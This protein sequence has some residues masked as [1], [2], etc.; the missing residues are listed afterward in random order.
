MRLCMDCDVTSQ[1]NER[2]TNAMAQHSASEFWLCSSSQRTKHW[3]SIRAHSSRVPFVSLSSAP[4]FDDVQRHRQT[5]CA[6]KCQAIDKMA[7]MR[8]AS[9]WWWLVVVLLLHTNHHQHTVLLLFLRLHICV[10]CTGDGCSLFMC[11]LWIHFWASY[12]TVRVVCINII[13]SSP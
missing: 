5:Q 12:K 3:I 4:L 11:I 10:R 1:R 2:N 9:G 8:R 7:F 13:I 6:P